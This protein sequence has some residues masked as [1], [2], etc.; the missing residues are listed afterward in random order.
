M[1]SG[2]HLD[3]TPEELV[4][5]RLYGVAPALVSETGRPGRAMDVDDLVKLQLHGV[6]ATTVR[7]WR[8]AGYT[9]LTADDLVK[10]AIN[11]VTPSWARNRSRMSVDEMVRSRQL[12]E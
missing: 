12:G 3:P 8:E 5:L 7:G 10:L 4:K 2:T 11:G 6:T 9:T 1:R